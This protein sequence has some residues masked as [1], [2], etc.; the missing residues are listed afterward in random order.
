[1]LVGAYVHPFRLEADRHLGRRLSLNAEIGIGQADPHRHSVSA[2]FLLHPSSR[3]LQ[4]SQLSG[5]LGIAPPS[6]ICPDEH[7]DQ[8]D[9]PPQ[10][11]RWTLS[12]ASEGVLRAIQLT[13]RGQECP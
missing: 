1:M 2:G 12:T 11:R 7:R 6:T 5:D 8:H 9:L 4:G 10:R 13:Q 3:S